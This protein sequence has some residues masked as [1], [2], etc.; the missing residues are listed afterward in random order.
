VCRAAGRRAILW[1]PAEVSC[2]KLEL[3]PLNKN[4]QEKKLV[5]FNFNFHVKIQVIYMIK[6]HFVLFKFVLLGIFLKSIMLNFINQKFNLL[7]TA[8]VSFILFKKN[9]FKSKMR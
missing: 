7:I 8:T 4:S 6:K 2:Y 3:R 1:G 5:N 9:I